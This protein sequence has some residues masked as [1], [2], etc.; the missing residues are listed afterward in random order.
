MLHLQQSDNINA[1]I[2][3]TYIYIYIY[4]PT[5]LLDGSTLLLIPSFSSPV[6]SLKSEHTRRAERAEL[7]H[8]LYIAKQ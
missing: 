2:L 3:H 5:L 1:S 7:D 4:T 6:C 8:L